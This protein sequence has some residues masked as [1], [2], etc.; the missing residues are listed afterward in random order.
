MGTAMGSTESPGQ[1][2]VALGAIVLALTACQTGWR[3]SDTWRKEQETLIALAVVQDLVN[4]PG[5]A[6]VLR[7][8]AL[9]IYGSTDAAG[10]HDPESRLIA[11]LRERGFDAYPVSQCDVFRVA[12]TRAA[13]VL[14]GVES[15]EWKDDAFVKAEGGQLC[16]IL[17]GGTWLYTLSRDSEAWTVDTVR[18]NKIF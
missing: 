17:C 11:M 4:M 18:R 12:A 10:P 7:G 3:R 13:A 5:D 14:V 1:R 15:L 9:C 16:G 6:A 8:T 2:V